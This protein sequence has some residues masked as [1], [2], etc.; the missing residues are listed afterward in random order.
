MLPFPKKGSGPSTGK[1]KITDENLDISFYDYIT[2]NACEGRY[3]R[4]LNLFTT[5]LF[6]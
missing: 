3:K 1:N 2:E 5:K 4:C 6:M